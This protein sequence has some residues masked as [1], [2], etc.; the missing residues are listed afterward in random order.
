MNHDIKEKSERQKRKR[1][2]ADV[3][4]LRQNMNDTS[5]F[6]SEMSETLESSTCEKQKNNN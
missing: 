4:Q 1:D 6:F 5:G 3:V 2:E